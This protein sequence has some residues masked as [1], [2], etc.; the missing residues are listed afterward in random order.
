MILQGSSRVKDLSRRLQPFLKDCASLLWNRGAVVAGINAWGNRKLAYR[1]RKQGVNHYEAQYFSMHVHCSPKVL[2][3][4]E[5]ALRTNELV[6]RWMSLKQE[7]VPKLPKVVRHAR[8]DHSIDPVDLA[9]DPAESAKYEYRNL[10]MQRIFEGRT[11][12][13]LLAEALARHRLVSIERQQQMTK[14]AYELS[15]LEAAGVS[16]S[17]YKLVRRKNDDAPGG[18]YLDAQIRQPP[19]PSLLPSDGT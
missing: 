4:L 13:D 11:K 7:S 16:L 1:I 15:E 8:R 14:T 19:P 18:S 17:T 5:G 10:V 2:N 12:Q 9:A 6:L 3:E